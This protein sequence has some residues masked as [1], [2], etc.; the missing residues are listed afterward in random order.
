MWLAVSVVGLGVVALAFTYYALQLEVEQPESWSYQPAPDAHALRTAE[1]KLTAL[2]VESQIDQQIHIKI[3]S[4]QPGEE[5]LLRASTSDD[6][7]VR[8]DS[9]AKFVADGAGHVDLAKQ[10]PPL[11]RTNQSTLW[12][13]SGQW[14]SLEGSD[15]GTLNNGCYGNISYPQKRRTAL[16][17]LTWRVDTQRWI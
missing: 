15:S 4:L 8:F 12:V 10:A 3:S 11:V 14:K 6:D 7:E 5:V 2:P 9:W 17:R 13:C 1:F 16:F